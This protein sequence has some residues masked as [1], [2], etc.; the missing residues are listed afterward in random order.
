MLVWSAIVSGFVTGLIPIGLAEGAALAIGT[1]QPPERALALLALFTVAHV[2]GKAPW[3]FLGSTADRVTARHPRAKGEVAKARELMAKHPVYGLG[4]LA[5]AAFASV[6]PFH[7]AA[8]AAGIARLPVGRF[9]V[10]C[11]VGRAL[12]FG[13]IAAVPSLVRALLA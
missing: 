4:V 5:A 9:L 11:L 12:R 13:L 1:L 2:A 10:V 6:P 3:Y 8:I 7:L